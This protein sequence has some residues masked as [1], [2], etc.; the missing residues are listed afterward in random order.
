MTYT[1]CAQPLSVLTT[2]AAGCPPNPA[3][4]KQGPGPQFNCLLLA[5][6]SLSCRPLQFSH[7]H[8]PF[9]LWLSVFS[10]HWFLLPP[11][12][13]SLSLP[14]LPSG[15]T[16]RSTE[17]ITY[18]WE[19]WKSSVSQITLPDIFVKNTSSPYLSVSLMLSL[20]RSCSHAWKDKKA[21]FCLLPVCLLISLGGL[22]M[23]P[24]LL[25]APL[26]WYFKWSPTSVISPNSFFC[27]PLYLM[28]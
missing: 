22:L 26:P 18:I 10:V 4:Q 7:L 1:G 25:P 20:P 21:S 9:K 15:S 11:F 3:A 14:L 8:L 16:V 28:I 5:R 23:W 27:S 6:T 17:V 2:E 13:G 19:C 24:H 12:P